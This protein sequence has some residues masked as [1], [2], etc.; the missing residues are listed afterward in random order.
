MFCLWLMFRL[1]VRVESVCRRFGIHMPHLTSSQLEMRKT[2]IVMASV[3]RSYQISNMFSRS[4]DS[5]EL[6][7]WLSLSKVFH[8][9]N[10]TSMEVF[11]DYLSFLY[12]TWCHIRI[13][14]WNPLQDNNESQ[15]LNACNKKLWD[16]WEAS[17]CRYFCCFNVWC[18]EDYS[19]VWKST[20][21]D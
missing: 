14:V 18:C 15:F 1:A 6:N 7:S 9:F 19:S 2:K 17:D 21:T 12:S 4:N 10:V 11:Y 13:S 16:S 3:S 8:S 5:F 20:T